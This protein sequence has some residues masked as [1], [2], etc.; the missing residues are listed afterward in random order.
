VKQATA[1]LIAGLMRKEQFASRSIEEAT[2]CFLRSPVLDALASGIETAHAATPLADG[3]LRVEYRTR[4]CNLT[5]PLAIKHRYSF[6]LLNEVRETGFLLDPERPEAASQVVIALDGAR[7]GYFNVAAHDDEDHVMA[8]SVLTYD[9]RGRL[10]PY[11][12]RTEDAFVS[13]LELG[14]ASLREE[15]DELGRSVLRLRLELPGLAAPAEVRVGYNTVGIHEVRTFQAEPSR[16]VV[17]SDLLL[18]D[19]P[20]LLAGDW[21]IGVTD[22]QDRMLVNAIVHVD[23]VRGAG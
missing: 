21:V 9:H 12:P 8:C 16:P 10:R 14:E 5:G 13:P 20:A 18:E 1:V 11:V 4:L 2:R 3:V 19:N 6:P 17:I 23:A 7:K 22:G 15:R